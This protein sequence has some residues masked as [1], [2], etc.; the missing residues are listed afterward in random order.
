M[1]ILYQTSTR[2]R[3]RLVGL[4]SARVVDGK[5]LVSV[6]FSHRMRRDPIAESYTRKKRASKPGWGGDYAFASVKLPWRPKQSWTRLALSLDAAKAQS[7]TPRCMQSLRGKFLGETAPPEADGTREDKFYSL[8]DGACFPLSA[9]KGVS[10]LRLDRELMG[11]EAGR[12]SPSSSS[13]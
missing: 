5:Q 3:P 8:W 7:A 2:I 9:G 13:S 11:K 4:C 6:P 12:Q 1:C 10:L